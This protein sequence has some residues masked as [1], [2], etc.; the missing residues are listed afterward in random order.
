MHIKHVLAII[1]AVCGLA[2]ALSSAN[3][4]VNGDFETPLVTNSGP[5]AGLGFDYRT[6]T[7]ITG[8][9]ITGPK[10]VQ[11]TS[12]YQPVGGGNQSVQLESLSPFTQSFATTPG[13]LYKLTFD[14]GAWDMN[15]LVTQSSSLRVDLGVISADYVGSDTAY[16]TYALLFT[17]NNA[18]TTL[19]FEN[20][21][22]FGASYPQLDDV[23]VEAVP[24]PGSIA[25]LGAAL[26]AFGL[27]R[28][29]KKA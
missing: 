29:R 24:E 6:G 10:E 17:A 20:L 11:F 1:I 7:Q 2:P 13:Q 14:L 3:L 23:S 27:S 25:L 8:W 16:V 9:T 5:P 15:D 4:I 22:P 28:R 19:S 12:Q 21:G 26:A 18:S